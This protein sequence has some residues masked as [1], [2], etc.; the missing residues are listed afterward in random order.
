MDY[1]PGAPSTMP[2]T[3]LLLPGIG[4]SGP[5]HWQSVW[6]SSFSH[7]HRV[8]QADWERPERGAW[9][10]GLER[11]VRAA[12]PDAMVVAHSLGCLAVAHWAVGPR[13]PVRAVMLVAAPDP[14]GPAFPAEATG[15]APLP[16][17]PLGLAGLVVVSDDDPYATPSHAERMAAAWGLEVARIGAAGHVNSESGLGPWP[18]GLALLHRLVAGPACAAG[19]GKRR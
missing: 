1:G 12:G 6:E 7:F 11:A 10:A 15:F 3:V 4:N 14:A 17:R 5:R 16:E 9:V 2:P 13:S 8:V 18:Q 19:P